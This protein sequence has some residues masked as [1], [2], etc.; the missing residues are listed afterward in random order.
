M[1]AG[2]A[3]PVP[4]IRAKHAEHLNDKVYCTVVPVRDCVAEDGEE[5]ELGAVLSK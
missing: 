2:L 5:P 3:M 4:V 1:A